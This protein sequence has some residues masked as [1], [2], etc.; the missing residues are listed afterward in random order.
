[1]L[2][3]R[4][5]ASSSASMPPEAPAKSSSKGWISRSS[6][7]LSSAASASL[8][9]IVIVGLLFVPPAI[10][11]PEAVLATDHPRRDPMREAPH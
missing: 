7:F 9:A 5:N 11:G 10:A 3:V 6:A 1:M 2:I 4:P 8:Y